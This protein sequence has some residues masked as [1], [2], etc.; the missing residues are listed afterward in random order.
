MKLDRMPITRGPKDETRRRARPRALLRNLSVGALHQKAQISSFV[1]VARH[2]QPGGIDRFRQRERAGAVVC[3]S[4]VQ[5]WSFQ[6][7]HGQL[8]LQN[9]AGFYLVLDASDPNIRS[10]NSGCSI[11]VGFFS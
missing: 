3:T 10:P 9:A 1:I 8:F 7:I 5:V 2:P 11:S 6:S 4:S